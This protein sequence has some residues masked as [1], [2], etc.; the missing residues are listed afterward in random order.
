MVPETRVFQAADGEDLMI[1]ACT[2]FDWSTRV[3]D[4]Q[5]DRIIAR[6]KW[7]YDHT[8]YSSH[9]VTIAATANYQDF[10]HGKLDSLDCSIG[11]SK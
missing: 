2:V 3:T 7:Q 8:K 11:V 10:Q 9:G 5:T 4:R 6:K 1:L